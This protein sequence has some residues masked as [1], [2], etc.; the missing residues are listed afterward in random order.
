MIWRHIV[1]RNVEKLEKGRKEK[2][3]N[4]RKKYAFWFYSWFSKTVF[5]RVKKTKKTKL[6]WVV[7]TPL[8][9]ALWRWRPGDH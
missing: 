8:I 1:I 4:K 5:N 6:Y 2:F 3:K 7:T 9:P